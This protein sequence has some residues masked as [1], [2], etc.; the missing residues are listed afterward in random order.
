MRSRA[1]GWRRSGPVC[2][3]LLGVEWADD[4]WQRRILPHSGAD[5]RNRV[6]AAGQRRSHPHHLPGSDQRT[7]ARNTPPNNFRG[8][9]SPQPCWW[10]GSRKLFC[11]SCVVN[12]R[13]RAG[14]HIFSQEAQPQVILR[15]PPTNRCGIPREFIGECDCRERRRPADGCPS[16]PVGEAVFLHGAVR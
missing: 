13:H 11:G 3:D 16:A 4:Q 10:L 6:R 8:Q 2:T 1:R 12:G 7:T 9:I 14:L 15:F 5:A